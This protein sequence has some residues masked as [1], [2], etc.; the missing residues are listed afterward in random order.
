MDPQS[1]LPS[2]LHGTVVARDGRGVLLRGPSG[3]GKSDLALRL[4][5]DRGFTLVADDR[6]ML[7][8]GS[9]GLLATAPETLKGLLEVRGLGIVPAPGGATTAALALV[10]DLC[11][12]GPVERLPETR[13]TILKGMA[14]PLV[15]LDP[16]EVAAAHKVDLALRCAEGDSTGVRPLGRTAH[17]PPAPR[18]PLVDPGQDSQPMATASTPPTG[19]G[20][21]PSP[22]RRV[23]LVTG[24]SGAGRTS[25]LR[26]LEDLGHEAVDNL[27]LYLLDA[28]MD[29]GLDAPHP[30]AL[31][32]DTRTRGFDLPAVL[33]ALDRLEANTAFETHLLFVD[34]DNEVLE[35]RFTE[36]RR[37]HPLAQDR[38]VADGI[39]M[40]RRLIA[41]LKDRATLRVDTS[42]LAPGQL[43]GM[44]EA[45]YGLDQEGEMTLFVTS[46]GFRN[47]LPREADLVFD[48]RFLANPHYVPELKA[49]SGLDPAVAA[50]VAAD[51]DYEV[52]FDR[53]TD[54]LNLLLPRYE[55]EGKSYLTIAVGC[56]GGKHRSVYTAERLAAWLKARGCRARTRHRDIRL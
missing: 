36:T 30:I 56:T 51:P 8:P 32:I 27:P 17:L 20:A 6:V 3:A 50:F 40:E 48:A 2:T 39:V 4:I 11:P 28:L 12:G 42:T 16:W 24:M 15:H 22:R 49:Q 37:R 55:R 33:G 19:S 10:V 53:M 54:L 38:P 41:P 47:G 31:G 52:F 5:L 23:V 14:I 18:S 43:K 46:F 26:A 44:L 1:P 21:P 7:S 25:A 29:T 45:A 34:C 35:R 13:S 9:D